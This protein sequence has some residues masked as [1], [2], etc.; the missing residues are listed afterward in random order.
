MYDDDDIKG[1]DDD[2]ADEVNR[3]P[4]A[5]ARRNYQLPESYK[6]SLQKYHAFHE[7]TGKA[8]IR[9]GFDKSV[10]D[11]A[12]QRHRTENIFPLIWLKTL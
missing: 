7:H 3:T 6:S 2:G 4:R 10:A 12:M 5:F 1:T 11:S 9:P 8:M